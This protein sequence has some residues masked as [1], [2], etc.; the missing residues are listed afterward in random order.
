MKRG[1][2][3]HPKM[4][5]LCTLLRKPNYAGVGI[6][7]SLWHLVA[8]YSPDGAIGR[9]ADHEI[10]QSLDWRGDP[11]NLIEALVV[12]GWLHRCDCHRLY[13]HDWE[14]HA[15]QTVARVLKNRGLSF[16]AHQPGASGRPAVDQPGTS[17]GPAVDQPRTR[18]GSAFAI[19]PVNYQAT[20][21][22]SVKS[23]NASTKLACLS[24]KPIAIAIANTVPASPAEV[25]KP[26]ADAFWDGFDFSPWFETLYALGP[27]KANKNQAR[28][29]LAS[30]SR[31]EDPAFRETFE[32][33]WR[34][35]AEYMAVD[36]HPKRT[37]LDW[38]NDE[39]WKDE[40]PKEVSKMEYQLEHMD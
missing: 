18:G 11:A 3:E 38:Y 25:M 15:D 10:A 27:K 7:E 40:I 6:L 9:L 12:S 23:P 13:V 14:D 32:A 34:K 29:M 26:T 4:K 2:P 39:G 17:L 22:E 36:F 20:D 28:Q 1:T 21:S 30:D 31:M 37:L 5:R 24:L 35:W 8:R 19:Q 33:G 16:V